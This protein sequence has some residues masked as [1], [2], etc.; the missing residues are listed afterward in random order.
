MKCHIAQFAWHESP[1]PLHMHLVGDI[2]FVVFVKHLIMPHRFFGVAKSRFQ[3]FVLCIAIILDLIWHLRNDVVHNL[4][5]PDPLVL[6]GSIHRHFNDHL[7]A[8]DEVLPSSSLAW[9]P[10]PW[11]RLNALLMLP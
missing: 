6:I 10:P 4:A 11:G 5:R 7:A 8:W 2:S 3:N 9:V 1:W